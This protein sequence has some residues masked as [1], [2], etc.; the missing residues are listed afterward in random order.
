M[1][2]QPNKDDIDF[3]FKEL[4][5]RP[6]MLLTEGEFSVENYITYFEGYFFGVKMF[7]GVNL[8][9]E[10]SKWFQNRIDESKRGRNMYWFSQ[11]KWVHENK[12]EKELIEELVNTLEMFFQD[13]F[14]ENR[15]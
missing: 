15:M 1:I 4:K 11:F 9:R 6:A 8:E 7:T 5:N 10:L 14:I 13:K 12:V 2:Q 3:L